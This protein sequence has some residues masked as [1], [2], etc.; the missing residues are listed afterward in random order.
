MRKVPLSGAAIL[1]IAAVIGCSNRNPNAPATVSGRVTY[2]G[3]PVPAGILTFHLEGKGGSHNAHLR[4]DGSYDLTDIPAGNAVV[5]VNTED[6]NPKKKK[7]D[8]DG[9]GA[10]DYA[11]RMAT[12]KPMKEAPP[13]YVAI[14]NKYTDQK[15]SP[16]KMALEGGR[17]AKDFDLAD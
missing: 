10:A 4:R 15:T 12:E 5:T 6:Y 8:Y 2:K 3:N 7:R 1:L 14:P 16:L 13:E 11:K 17:Q 9:K